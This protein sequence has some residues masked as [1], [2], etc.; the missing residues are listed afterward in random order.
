MT[1][2]FDPEELADVDAMARDLEA[3]AAS[4]TVP[5]TPDFVDRVMLAVD[6]EPLAAPAHVAGLALRRGAIGT[7]LAAF[8]DAGRVAMRSGFPVAV[9]AQAFALVLVV[10]ALA[11]GSGV[12]TA[13]ALGFMQ[14]GDALPSPRP[15]V[16][17]PSP[18]SDASPSEPAPSMDA[19]SMQPPTSMAPE[20]DRHGRYAGARDAPRPRSA[21]DDHGGSGGRAPARVP[22]RARAAARTG[23]R[24]RRGPLARVPGR[25]AG[26]TAT[27]ATTTTAGTAAATA[28]PRRRRPTRARRPTPTS[29]TTAV[30]APEVRRGTADALGGA[31]AG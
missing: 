7:F 21:T 26:T 31:G 22:A 19:P 8:A 11:A 23:P 30:T 17:R 27:T 29:R 28:A 24:G 20:T 13:G 14:G 6:A 25:A 4:T 9:R 16:D 12:A 2:P 3:L 18:T 10:A 1:A 5:P 15:P